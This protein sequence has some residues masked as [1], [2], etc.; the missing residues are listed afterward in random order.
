VYKDG[1]NISQSTRAD[2]F[3][4]KA[5]DLGVWR[6]VVAT[7]RVTDEELAALVSNALVYVNLSLY[8]GFGLDRSKLCR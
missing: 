4:R 8:E 6:D 1:V 2:I 5:E 3:Q 7:G